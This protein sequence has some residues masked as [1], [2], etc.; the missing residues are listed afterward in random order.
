MDSIDLPR[1]WVGRWSRMG[2]RSG[3]D[4]LVFAERLTFA[5]ISANSID[6]LQ[7]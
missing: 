5:S 7:N 1:Q 4:L 2:P 6:Y 3:F